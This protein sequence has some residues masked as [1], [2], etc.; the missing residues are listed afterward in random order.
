VSQA[1]DVQL[2][3]QLADAKLLQLAVAKH[4]HAD[5]MHLLVAEKLRA[6]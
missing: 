4:L 6:C 5:A 1:A 2:Q 3:L